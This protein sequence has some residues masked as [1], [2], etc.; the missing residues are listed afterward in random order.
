MTWKVTLGTIAILAAAVLSMVGCGETTDSAD[1]QS[2]TTTAVISP[3]ITG[4]PTDF[5][6][7]DGSAPQGERPQMPEIDYAAAA[8][9]LGVTEQQLQD[10]LVT[11]SQRP[12]D[13]SAAASTLGITEEALRDALGFQAGNRMPGSPPGGTPPAGQGGRLPPGGI[14]ETN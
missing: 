14:P 10:A 4:G 8:A 1:A 13:F 12:P 9:K 2:T 5:Q 3:E 11:D 6:P 7:P